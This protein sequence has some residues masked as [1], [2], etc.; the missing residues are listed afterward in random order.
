MGEDTGEDGRCWANTQLPVAM[1]CIVGKVH[2]SFWQHFRHEWVHK[3]L[4]VLALWKDSLTVFVDCYCSADGHSYKLH[5]SV[6]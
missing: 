3:L 2:R 5:P 1:D 4:F 6:F